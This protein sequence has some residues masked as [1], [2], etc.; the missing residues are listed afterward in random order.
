MHCHTHG[1]TL[2]D[3]TVSSKKVMS[4]D[5]TTVLAGMM[6][7]ALAAC[8]LGCGS[9]TNHP[10]IGQ[11]APPFAAA[12]L[13]ESPFELE[14]HLG[15]SVIILDFWATWCGPCVRALP[16]VSEVAAK[17]KDQGVEVFAVNVQEDPASVQAFLA[18]HQLSMP[19]VLDRDGRISALYRA[20]AIPQTVIIGKDGNVHVVHVGFSGDLQSELSRE[21]DAIVAGKKL[22]ARPEPLTVLTAAFAN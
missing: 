19:V 21:L 10:L 22:V 4:L 17:Y 7:L 9:P 20:E 3:R 18:E 1:P 14:Q 5:W 15:K 8:T 6:A 12:M 2:L 13:D 11:K 16:I